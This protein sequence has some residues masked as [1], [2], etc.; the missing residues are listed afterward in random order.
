MKNNKRRKQAAASPASRHRCFALRAARAT[1]AYLA[2]P[3]RSPFRTTSPACF[4][5]SH[6]FIIIEH[7][8]YT[9]GIS[10]A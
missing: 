7:Y 3:A 9:H 4:F 8:H 6:I 1:A 10:R 2:S 5:T